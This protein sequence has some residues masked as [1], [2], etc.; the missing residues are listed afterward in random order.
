MEATTGP[1]QTLRRPAAGRVAGGVCAGLAEYLGVDVLWVRA[2]FV[3]F[4]LLA[5]VGPLLYAVG[6]AMIPGEGS[7]C[8]LAEGF[9]AGGSGMGAGAGAGGVWGAGAG[10]EAGGAGDVG[11]AGWGRPY[12]PYPACGRHRLVRIA[13][14]FV[15]LWLLLHAVTWGRWQ[16]GF[17]GG[18]LWVVA[19]GTAAAVVVARRRGARPRL[20][21]LAG[22]AAA[23]VAA[24]ALA[25]TVAVVSV[26]LA[27]GVS[28]GGGLGSRQWAPAR[29]SA[30]SHHYRLAAG[31]AELDLLS[32]TLPPGTTHVSASVGVGRL[33]VDVPP[34]MP[35]SV[36][37]ASTT[38]SVNVFGNQDSGIGVDR[39]LVVA[40]PP[41]ASGASPAATLVLSARVAVGEVVVR[42][43]G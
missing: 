8:S 13:A 35:V 33:V 32:L 36:D 15:A 16:W 18:G 25:L 5:G 31:D 7:S 30:L 29:V 14:L 22:V 9:L 1:T 4:T 21:L 28:V 3:V 37:A 26:V 42:R 10:G 34:D 11:G 27:S 38:G 12:G 20:K 43:A 19:A 17:W 2:G 24:V 40:S 23:G 39:S 41:P 6:W